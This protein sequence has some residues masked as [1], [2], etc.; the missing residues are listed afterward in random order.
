M[1]EDPEGLLKLARAYNL[2]G[3]EPQVPFYMHQGTGLEGGSAIPDLER[4]V[5]DYGYAGYLTDM[6]PQRAAAL[7]DPV[8][9]L[10]AIERGANG[11][12]EGGLVEAQ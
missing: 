5:R 11:Y 3:Y 2:P 9:G 4:L 6:G 12:A 1:Q 8:G 10:R 7:Y